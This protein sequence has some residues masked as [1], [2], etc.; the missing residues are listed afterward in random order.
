MIF[1]KDEVCISGLIDKIQANSSI[2]YTSQLQVWEPDKQGADHGK[3]WAKKMVGDSTKASILDDDLFYTK[4]ILVSTNWNK[5]DDV[6]DRV[7][8][9][10]ARNTPSHKR[11][12]IEH[13]EHKL[14][15][16]IT[17]VWAM[18]A[19]GDVI[20]DD[21]AIDDLPNLYHLVNGAVIYTNWRDEE[22]ID[23]TTVLIE[24]IQKGEKFVSME[25]LFSNFSYAI[26]TPED[27][28]HILARCEETS[29]L[30]KHLRAY[31]GEGE[32]E[33]C[34]IGRVIKNIVFSGKGYVDKPANDESIILQSGTL[35]F[36][37][38]KASSKN[39]FKQESGVSYSYAETLNT[40]KQEEGIIMAETT[41][42]AD[43]L[44]RQNDKLEK[45]VSTLQAKVEEL[46]TQATADG[47]KDLENRITELEAEV[48][49]A[50]KMTDEEK[51][52]FAEMQKAKSDLQTQLDEVVKAKE[53]AE[54]T[55]VELETSKVQ[56][57]RVAK[58]VDGGMSREKAE[59]KVELFASFNEAQFEAVASELI[60]AVKVQK[61]GNQTSAPSKGKTGIP[62]KGSEEEE[63][64]T[65]DDA[66]VNA[67]ES[68][69][70]D[71]EPSD[72]PSLSVD[73]SQENEE[74]KTEATRKELRMAL[75]HYLP[76][77]GSR[78]T[79]NEESAEEIV[80]E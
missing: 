13:N 23:R 25:A 63:D 9:W 79:Q 68:V 4:S 16:H 51:K 60:A 36:D 65:V 41:M 29:F 24:Q 43:L 56:A 74:E 57:D 70:T 20:S 69:V 80:N 42:N 78:F 55:L 59:A 38:S 21:T 1:Y 10:S 26:R 17:D 66:S 48:L 8:V 7:E 73:A 46:Q 31:G 5:N 14:V 76:H 47:I 34:K 53:E 12:N 19:S 11:T 40:S 61:Q 52:K 22:L 30:T 44:Q 67:D 62:V 75:A 3:A 28:F 71:V 49:E 6:F 50:K 45:T 27:E 64:I 15:G 18:D 72:D 77:T 33:G 54:A 35:A 32:F 2:A 39:P 58:L 37:F